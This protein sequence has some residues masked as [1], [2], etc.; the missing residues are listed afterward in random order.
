MLTPLLSVAQDFSGLWSG[1]GAQIIGS[2]TF[3]YQAEIHLKVE[4]KRISGKVVTFDAGT[5]NHSIIEIGGTI[6]NGKIKIFT[7]RILKISYP[8]PKFDFLCFRNFRGEIVIDEANQLLLMEL[9]SYG[10]DLKYDLVTKQYSDG[11]CA[12]STYRFTKKYEGKAAMSEEPVA[13]LAE[14][15]KEL[16]VVDQKEIKLSKPVVKI[17][18]WDNNQ[19]DGDLVNLYLNG[20]LLRSGI[21]VSRKGEVFEL[22]LSSGLNLIEVEAINEGRVS[23]NTSAISV[24]TE[25]DQHDI[26]LRARKGEKDAL[27]IFLD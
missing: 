27:K 6:K 19:E 14:V 1:T 26:M 15:K 20:R 13:A 16:I 8:E 3:N 5:K 2:R 23:P 11:N 17:K 22:E 10:I 4:G 18:V 7:D 24:F 9:E 25:N 21:E 12:P